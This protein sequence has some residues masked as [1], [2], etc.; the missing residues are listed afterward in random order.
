MLTRLAT[1]L[2]NAQ[3][4][5]QWVFGLTAPADVPSAEHPLCFGYTYIN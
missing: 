2:I 3:T 4:H 5:L 1:A